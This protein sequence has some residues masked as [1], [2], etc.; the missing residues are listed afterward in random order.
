MENPKNLLKEGKIMTRHCGCGTLWRIGQV[1]GFVVLIQVLSACTSTETV[2]VQKDDLARVSAVSVVRPEFVVKRG[3]SVAWRTEILWVGDDVNGSYREALAPLDI[4]GEIERQLN[5]MGLVFTE[6]A[7]ADYVLVAVVMIGES[8]QGSAM[9]ELVRLYPSLG[10]VSRTLQ[11]GTLM[12]G[13]S[14]PGSPV[15][16]WRGAIQT[17]LS[18]KIPP[19]ERKVRLQSV[20]RSLVNTLPVD[21]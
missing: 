2:V 9:E 4:Q 8:A 1:V 17:Y 7:S 16:L 10:M 18:A 21:S 20:V 19:S 5:D 13:L 3:E 15:I 14:H 12:L 6:P 11:K